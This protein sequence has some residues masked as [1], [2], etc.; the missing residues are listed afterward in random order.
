MIYRILQLAACVR[1]HPS[2]AELLFQEA[3]G[4]H[5]W[6]KLL[7]QA[8]HHGMGPL[9][10]RHLDAV[11]ASIPDHFR[12]AL[13]LLRV[14]H[15]RANRI[16]MAAL[17]EVLSLFEKEGVDVLVLKGAAIGH[18]VYPEIGLRPMR[19][20]DVLVPEKDA[21]L[22]QGILKTIGYRASTKP[23]PPDHYH[24]PP[25]ERPLDGLSV[26][27]EIHHGLYPDIPPYYRH[28]LFDS[29]AQSA[30]S[31]DLDGFSARAFGYEEMLLHL[32][33]HGFTMPII[34]EPFRL[35]AVADI[36]GLVEAKTDQID[37]QRLCS[38]EPRLFTVLSQFHHLTP[39]HPKV[40]EKLAL[41]PGR[42]PKG[43][44]RTFDGWP[45]NRLSEC[46]NKHL[47][48]ILRETLFPP[49]WWFDIYYGISG[50]IQRLRCRLVTHPRHLMWW[51]RL[52]GSHF[53]H[54]HLKAAGE[55]D[56][57]TKNLLGNKL[58]R[59]RIVVG[60]FISKLF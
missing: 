3:A 17:K 20:I 45:K 34:Y 25:L 10:Y 28:P 13:N 60:A 42:P 39:W 31:F 27:V 44:G 29:L 43:V 37:W 14:R 9:L 1:S 58:R 51:V 16:R 30:I 21:H 59:I 53:C 22:A 26:C 18:L 38:K 35:M 47:F 41:K 11:G 32:Y 52:Y 50:R 46:K 5:A 6:D 12:R 33:Q 48:Q 49:P 40:L 24:L 19:D 56:T 4:F 8:E 15:R 57:N 7:Y 36:I 2:R 23:F 55:G 54:Y